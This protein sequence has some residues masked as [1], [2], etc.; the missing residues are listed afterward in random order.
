MFFQGWV[1]GILIKESSGYGALCIVLMKT[2]KGGGGG[3]Y[4][5]EI[6]TTMG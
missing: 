1:N 6:G 2:L 4:L 3:L 5:S